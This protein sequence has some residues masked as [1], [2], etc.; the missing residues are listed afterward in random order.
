MVLKF[1]EVKY[2]EFCM[3]V[4]FEKREIYVYCRE[5]VIIV[6]W[7]Q[8]EVNSVFLIYFFVLNFVKIV[9][10]RQVFKLKVR[11]VDRVQFYFRFKNDNVMGFLFLVI[12]F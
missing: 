12:Y 5:Q 9:I 4:Q 8:G 1:R 2:L 7:E 11:G 3:Q 10:E 6:I